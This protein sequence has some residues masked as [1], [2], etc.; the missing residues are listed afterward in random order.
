MLTYLMWFVRYVVF[1]WRWYYHSC[2]TYSQHSTQMKKIFAT[3]ISVC[4]VFTTSVAKQWLLPR[5]CLAW[6]SAL[7]YQICIIWNL[8][9][10]SQ[11]LLDYLNAFKDLIIIKI[12]GIHPSPESLVISMTCF[13]LVY[14]C[15]FFFYCLVTKWSILLQSH[16]NFMVDQL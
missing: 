14:L 16:C 10:P 11:L 15:C 3:N 13:F 8:C 1:T 6:V 5:F 2:D 9:I 12:F 7:S 4:F